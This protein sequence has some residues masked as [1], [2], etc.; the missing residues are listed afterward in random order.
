MIGTLPKMFDEITLSEALAKECPE[1]LFEFE[2]LYSSSNL[3]C[4]TLFA[5]KKQR[6][7]AEK[8]LRTI[9]FSQPLNPTSR[10]PAVKSQRLADKSDEL[11]KKDDV[12]IDA[13]LT[14]A[15]AGAKRLWLTHFSQR[16]ADP[17]EFLPNAAAMFP[18]AECGFDGKRMTL[19]FDKR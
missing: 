12:A 10:T 1:L 17:A 19:E 3:T 6:P 16:I 14:A 2:I 13:G 11:Q 15:R 8:A 7:Q 18:A 5:P 9:G 4:I